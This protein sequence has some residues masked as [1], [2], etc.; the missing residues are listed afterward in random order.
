MATESTKRQKRSRRQQKRSARKA[1]KRASK[2]GKKGAPTITGPSDG[3]VFLPFQ[4]GL[5]ADGDPTRTPGDDLAPFEL[6]PTQAAPIVPTLEDELFG[7]ITEAAANNLAGDVDVFDA[8]LASL[9]EAAGGGGKTAVKA[10]KALKV[11]A[12]LAKQK[13]KERVGVAKAEGKSDLAAAKQFARED[14]RSRNREEELVDA[15]AFGVPTTLDRDDVF[16]AADPASGAP[17]SGLQGGLA[18]FEAALA[19]DAQAGDAAARLKGLASNPLVLAGGG[20]LLFML[21]RRKRR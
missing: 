4:P 5:T 14:R 1:L 2:V 16:F 21:I 18:G 7:S 20:L 6:G 12:K 15:L 10:R 13:R 19:S 9:L 3:P 8:G 11:A 17:F